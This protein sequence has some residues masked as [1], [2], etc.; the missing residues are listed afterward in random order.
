MKLTI[1]TPCSRPLNLPAIYASI[2][3]MKQENVEWIIVYDSD[4]IDERIKMYESFVPII[5]TNK[6]R[7][8]T[9]G[10]LQRNKALDIATGD[11]IYYLDDDNLV[12]EKLYEKIKSYG[13]K[14]KILIFN[15]F[16]TNRK[17]RIKIYHPKYIRKGYIDTAQIIIPSKFKYVKWKDKDYMEDHEYLL[18]LIK[19]VGIK[20]IKF[21]DK[22]FSYRNYLRRYDV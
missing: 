18:E 13:E 9:N 3:N 8:N 16:A 10:S 14:D 1:I 2:L 19:E 5:L 4:E 15:Q 20:K 22:L 17:R 12:H 7:G 21:I 6:K 11:F